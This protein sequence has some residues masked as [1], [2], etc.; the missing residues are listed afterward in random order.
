MYI[1]FKV[2]NLNFYRVL[3]HDTYTSHDAIGKV[4][5]DLK[6]L[7]NKNGPNLISGKIDVK[8]LD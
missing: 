5:I 1:F 7:L 6:P 2:Y 4:Y 3:D 8:T